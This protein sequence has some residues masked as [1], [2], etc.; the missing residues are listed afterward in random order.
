[1]AIRTVK[2]VVFLIFLSLFSAMII[3]SQEP[4]RGLITTEDLAKL[5]NIINSLEEAV[6]A[7]D[8]EVVYKGY[9]DDN[10]LG[11]YR[12]GEKWKQMEW[13]S[14]IFYPEFAPE[15][16]VGHLKRANSIVIFKHFVSSISI[17]KDPKCEFLVKLSGVRSIEFEAGKQYIVTEM[18]FCKQ[19]TAWILQ[20]V[21]Y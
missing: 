15:N 19:D 17:F 2:I 7:H 12:A 18:T 21:I 3:Q 8:W 4:E 5:F 14:R 16:T 11:P 20:D 9:M 10:L 13:F 6:V 1:M